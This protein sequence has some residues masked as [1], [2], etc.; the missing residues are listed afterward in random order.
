M[1]IPK[2]IPVSRQGGNYTAHIGLYGPKG[3]RD[4]F[5]AQIVATL[6]EPKP[7]TPPTS[8][9]RWYVVLHKF[10]NRGKHIGTEHWFAGTTADGEEQVIKRARAKRE[11]T[12]GALENVEFADI[13]VA[14]FQ[15][16][17]DGEVFGLVDVSEPEA[18]EEWA[19]RV[20]M[21]PGDLLF[22]APWDGS[23]D[24]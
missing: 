16:T 17:I 4:Q 5:S 10:T 22:T 20:E 21:K 12:I 19:D 8:G 6:T 24:D 9:K 2:L 1:A 15:V 11:A 23:Y 13:K 7:G 18:G 3:K 14:L